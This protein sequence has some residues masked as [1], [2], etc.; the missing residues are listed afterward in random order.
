MLISVYLE[1]DTKK[2]NLV[3]LFELKINVSI[4]KLTGNYLSTGTF[5]F[6]RRAIGIKDYLGSAN[7]DVNYNH[8]RDLGKHYVAVPA[9]SSFSLW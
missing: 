7:K 4:G 2:K 1:Y 3:F 9:V 6:P 5:I 8:N